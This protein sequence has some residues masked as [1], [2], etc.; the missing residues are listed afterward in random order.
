MS[1]HFPWRHD[2]L[3]PDRMRD[4][5]HVPAA[6]TTPDNGSRKALI[7]YG[8][9]AVALITIVAAVIVRITWR[10]ATKPT[11]ILDR[12]RATWNVAPSE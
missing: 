6:S 3:R 4:P 10:P 1:L 9:L 8:V 2:P 12:S 5:D 7:V 11:R